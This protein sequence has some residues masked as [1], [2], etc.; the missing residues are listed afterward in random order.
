MKKKTHRSKSVTNISNSVLPLILKKIRD[1]IVFFSSLIQI[2]NGEG[3]ER[4][5]IQ[6]VIIRVITKSNDYTAGVPFFFITSMITER[7]GRHEVLLSI[8]LKKLQFPRKG[9]WPIF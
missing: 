8:N 1:C 9:E 5:P 6:S 7:V 3:T 2:N 4:S